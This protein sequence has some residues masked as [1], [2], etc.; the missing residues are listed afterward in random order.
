MNP[1]TISYG[2]G[3]TKVEVKTYKVGKLEF[4]YIDGKFHNIRLGDTVLINWLYPAVRDR[5]WGTV[6]S[7]ITEQSFAVNDNSAEIVFTCFYSDGDIKFRARNRLI[8]K[9]NK[10][11]YSFD[12]V[13]QSTFLKN[14]IGINVL[15]PIAPCKGQQC[16][17]EHPNGDMN[18]ALF[19][20]LISPHQPFKNIQ[21]MSWAANGKLPC[22]L[23]FEGDVFEAEDQRNWTDNSY[24]IYSTPLELPFPIKILKGESIFQKITF[25]SAAESDIV[26]QKEEQVGININ[27]AEKFELPQIGIAK[28]SETKQ[29]SE[30]EIAN[31]KEINFS[32]YRVDLKLFNN[33]WENVFRTAVIESSALNWPLELAIHFSGEFE[34]EYNNFTLLI[35]KLNPAIHHFLIFDQNHLSNNNLLS[36]VILHLRKDFPGADIGAGADAY[37]AELSRTFKSQK[38][39]DFVSYV[40]CPQ[41]HA[42]DNLSIIENLDGQT[43]TV[44]SAKKEFGLPVSIGAITLKQRFNVVATSDKNEKDD[45]ENLPSSVDIRQCS[46]FAAEWILG[47]INRLA[48]SRVRS[49]T[50]FETV[51]MK[52]ILKGDKRPDSLLLNY[53]CKKDRYP[54]YYIFREILKH[55]DVKIF[56]L[57]SSNKDII[58]GLLFTSE[59]T[60]NLFLVNYTNENVKVRVSGLPSGDYIKYDFNTIPEETDPISVKTEWFYMKSKFDTFIHSGISLYIIAKDK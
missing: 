21:A 19:P 45:P 14:R 58:D 32:F 29:L 49:A 12:G 53:N 42:F 22:K 40:I 48:F 34:K 23:L 24:K 38:L 5:N 28:S 7:K 30:N 35:K 39:V 17:I 31:L 8:I 55:K 10:L 60:Y 20:E 13:A 18:T 2:S 47:S 44:L 16:T 43:D 25:E 36:F 46:L 57:N 3:E 54:L 59:G 4:D 11:T 37:Y 27:I 41:V 26:F 9:N 1:E 51:G 15:L 56:H 52:G 33:E 50:F 6:S